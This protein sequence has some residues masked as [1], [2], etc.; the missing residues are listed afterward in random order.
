MGLISLIFLGVVL[1]LTL[2]VVIL[3]WIIRIISPKPSDLGMQADKK[4]KNCPPT[5]NCVCSQCPPT[6]TNYL[7]SIKFD[8]TT[9]QAMDR[10]LEVLLGFPRN[11][12]VEQTHD[13]LWV[14]FRSYFWGFR[15]DVEF[16]IDEPDQVIHFR[17]AARL[18]K[19]DFGVNRERV[20]MIR[21]V[22]ENL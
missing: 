13:Y 20:E 11:L 5:P 10:I 22:F 15:D 2:L 21:K 12:I 4:L 19:Y 9:G 16:L 7:S 1:G 6:A 3:R 18:G 8:G 17:S 14:E